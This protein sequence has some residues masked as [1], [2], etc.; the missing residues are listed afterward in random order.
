M[1]T[2]P[3]QSLHDTQRYDEANVIIKF[4]NGKIKGFPDNDETVMKA[5]MASLK[6]DVPEYIEERFLRIHYHKGSFKT[7]G[8]DKFLKPFDCFKN[9]LIS[10]Y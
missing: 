3:Y 7:F 1:K 9:I 4:E 8:V 5:L 6:I 10:G 2:L